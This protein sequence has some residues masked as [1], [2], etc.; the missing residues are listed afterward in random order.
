MGAANRGKGW[1]RGKETGSASACSERFS[2]GSRGEFISVF[3][4]YIVYMHIC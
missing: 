3:V 1:V 2:A 4:L